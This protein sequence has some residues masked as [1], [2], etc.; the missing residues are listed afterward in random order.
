MSPDPEFPVRVFAVESEPPNDALDDEPADN[1]RAETQTLESLE[2]A[3]QAFAGERVE[4]SCVVA[5]S[6][7]DRARLELVRSRW[8]ELPEEVRIAIVS[9]STDLAVEHVALHFAR[10]L[11]IALNDPSPLVRQFAVLGLTTYDDPDTANTLLDHFSHDMSEDVRAEAAAALGNWADL[12]DTSPAGLELARRIWNTLVKFAMQ[13]S[14]SH[15]VRSNAL[16]SASR[17]ETDSRIRNLID[18]FYAEDETGLRRSAVVAMGNSG[19][20]RWAPVIL[21]E[22]FSE[23]NELRRVAADALGQLGDPAALPDL[24]KATKDADTDARHAAIWA[25]GSISGPA[26]QRIL[27]NLAENPLPEDLRVIQEAMSLDEDSDAGDESESA[28]FL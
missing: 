14:E 17:F 13:P 8:H 25:I 15:H 2:E 6:D 10:F 11:K 4:P 27:S 12:I 22:L 3:F 5:L 19:D 18:E 28:P 1:W 9:S 23:D 21:I 7:L 24:L 26:A 20:E 16:E